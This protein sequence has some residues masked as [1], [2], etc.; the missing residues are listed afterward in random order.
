M[1][2]PVVGTLRRTVFPVGLVARTLVN[3]LAGHLLRGI[4]GHTA[5]SHV[6][7]VTPCVGVEPHPFRRSALRV[8]IA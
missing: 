5:I 8:R 4:V 6:G 2:E 1:A 7:R 3:L